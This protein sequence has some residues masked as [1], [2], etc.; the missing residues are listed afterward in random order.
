V[1]CRPP[2]R[3][4][5]MRVTRK[6]RICHPPAEQV[7]ILLS[8]GKRGGIERKTGL[9]QIATV[10]FLCKN[11]DLVQRSS[12]KC[13]ERRMN[14]NINL[15]KPDSAMKKYL[16]GASAL[17][18][19]LTVFLPSV[20]L[21]FACGN[22][23]FL[24][25]WYLC[26][27]AKPP[28]RCI[29]KIVWGSALLNICILLYTAFQKNDILL[30]ARGYREALA[31]G[32]VLNENVPAFFRE[33]YY[34]ILLGTDSLLPTLFIAPL[35]HFFGG[36]FTV[37]VLL[38]FNMFVVPFFIVLGILINEINPKCVPLMFLF[39][40]FLT[41]VFCG[42]FDCAGLLCV[43]LWL[44]LIHK[45]T[46]RKMAVSKA[47]VLGLLSVG[48]LLMRGWYLFYLLGT[49]LAFLLSGAIRTIYDK[50]FNMEIQV[51]NM[52]IVGGTALLIVVLLFK[53]YF[54]QIFRIYAEPMELL[55]TLLQNG[56]QFLSYYGILPLLFYGLG[57]AGLFRRRYRQYTMFLL[58]QIPI[59]FLLF[60]SI[61][62]MEPSHQYLIAAELLLLGIIGVTAL[63]KWNTRVMV[64]FTV[65][66][67]LN[68]AYT[69]A[70]LSGEP[71]KNVFGARFIPSN[72]VQMEI[73]QN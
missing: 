1:V 13:W 17:L 36:S 5:G 19:L 68:F 42:S 22:L 44:Y 20:G 62:I 66:L 69:F 73:L 24:E 58:L 14:T 25:V 57:V 51:K 39:A 26:K 3:K 33:V 6:Q 8:D 29:K 72:A 61:Q 67:A 50:K 7:K 12:N 38:V 48:M 30:L 47:I 21:T 56:M 65:V 34:S 64:A 15:M 52:L 35:L 18:L 49:I 31:C 10:P 23:V 70:P 43:A 63:P 9:L 28:A 11:A 4:A 71:L 53:T 45:R 32:P 59:T 27:T 40:P 54:V 41:P 2:A 55:G 37:Y 16:A 46:F 60:A